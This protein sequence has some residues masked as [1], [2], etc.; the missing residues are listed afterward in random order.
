M[1]KG[2]VL[3]GIVERVDFPNKGI[4]VCEGGACVVK[5]AITGQKVSFRIHKARKGKAEGRLLEVLEKSPLESETESSCPH[6]GSCGGCV[7]MSLPYGEQLKLKEGQVRRLLEPVL[8]K[9]ETP[10]VYDGM[11]ASP[12]PYGYRN[13]MEFSFGDEVKDGPLALGMHKRGSFYDIVTVDGCRIVDGDF[14]R[15]LTCAKEYF[16]VADRKSVV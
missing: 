14:R 13:K 1:K 12:K 4:V 11:K 8:G 6:F 2:E 7:Y 9:Q 15:I 10:Y 5:N 16:T 3:E